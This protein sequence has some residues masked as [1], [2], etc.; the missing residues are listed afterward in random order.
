MSDR[1]A[2][3][4]TFENELQA[5]RAYAD[6]SIKF[7]LS[8]EAGTLFASAVRYIAL[9]GWNTDVGMGGSLTEWE[10]HGH[11]K[12]EEEMKEVVKFLTSLPGYTGEGS[13][14]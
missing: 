9:P 12:S 11:T 8:K 3:S 6:T 10:V 5:L 14:G 1:Y 13:C 2:F 4:I 7:G